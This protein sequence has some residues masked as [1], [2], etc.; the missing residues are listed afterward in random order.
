MGAISV[1]MELLRRNCLAPTSPVIM[2]D[3]SRA[4]EEV[5]RR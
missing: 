5:N 3:D 4:D 1:E 2:N